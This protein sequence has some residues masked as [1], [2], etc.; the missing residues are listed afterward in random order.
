MNTEL[1]KIP[2]YNKILEAVREFYGDNEI[3][4]LI[5]LDADSRNSL[6]FMRESET[7]SVKAST[8]AKPVSIRFKRGRM[9][10]T[11]RLVWVFIETLDKD[12][13]T[14]LFPDNNVFDTYIASPDKAFSFNQFTKEFKIIEN[15]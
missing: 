15:D 1:I 13:F 14:S 11:K 3:D 2:S 8:F 9:D 10:D 6:V 4:D 5:F 7:L 12:T